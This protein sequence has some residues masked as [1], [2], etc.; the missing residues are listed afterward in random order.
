MCIRLLSFSAENQV[1]TDFFESIGVSKQVTCS[2]QT[3]WLTTTKLTKGTRVLK[4]LQSREKD[5]L[6]KTNILLMDEILH[7]L[8]WWIYNR[9]QGFIHLRCCRISSINSS[10]WKWMVE[11]WKTSF[12]WGW[13]P[14]RCILN[15]RERLLYLHLAE[16]H[17]DEDGDG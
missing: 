9:L 10:T 15:F 3:P 17:L 4:W 6:P 14:D 1:S 5:T 12:L 11:S 16:F 7:Q 8:I 2:K 13:L